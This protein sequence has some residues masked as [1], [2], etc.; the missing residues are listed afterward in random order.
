MVSP[1]SFAGDVLAGSTA[2][3]GLILVYLGSLAAGYA[4]YDTTQ[5]PAVRPSFQR[6]AWFG[7]VGLAV[8]ILAA[9]FALTAK[10]AGVNWMASTAAILLLVAFVWGILTALLT[11]LEIR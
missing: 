10:W 2:L 3:A 8:A 1:I 4:A 7:F 11:V 9:A 6:R 5:Q